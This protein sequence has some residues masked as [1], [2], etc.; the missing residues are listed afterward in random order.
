MEV[1]MQTDTKKID[2]TK[3]A[4][5][6]EEIDAAAAVLESG[7]VI[8]GAQTQALEKEFA[9]FVGAAHAVATNGCTMALYL[10]IKHM[11][12]TSEDEVIV[13]SLTWTAT[14]SVVIQAGA[15]P[16]FADVKREDWC[17]DP[18]DVAERITDRTRLLFQVRWR[19]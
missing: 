1:L 9:E 4:I 6:Q 11:N 10:A 14:A 19:F 12:L 5:A 16:V 3:P 15:T 7:W 13:P 17:L 2:L 18:E 8:R